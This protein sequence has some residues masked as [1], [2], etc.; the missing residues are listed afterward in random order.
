MWTTTPERWRLREEYIT[1]SSVSEKCC[2][3]ISLPQ[4]DRCVSGVLTHS[5]MY[6]FMTWSS[7]FVKL[8]P[9]VSRW[10]ISHGCLH[11][12][13]SSFPIHPLAKVEKWYWS[14]LLCCPCTSYDVDI[15]W[16]D[17]QTRVLWKA[18]CERQT[19]LLRNFSALLMNLHCKHSL[20]FSMEKQFQW[21]IHGNGELLPPM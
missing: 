13:M 19:G 6:L 9:V 20:L 16:Q 11:D 18:F 4:G 12:G 7:S 15:V 1:S 14:V 2:L 17:G 10:R 5:V 21:V 8:Y 3:F